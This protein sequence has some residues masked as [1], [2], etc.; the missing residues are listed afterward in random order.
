MIFL[1]LV[2]ALV[3]VDAASRRAPRTAES[4]FVATGTGMVVPIASVV[5]RESEL[6]MQA[7]REGRG[8]KAMPIRINGV[9]D[10]LNIVIQMIRTRLDHVAD[11]QHVR[12]SESIAKHSDKIPQ[13]FLVRALLPRRLPTAI[14]AGARAAHWVSGGT[15]ARLHARGGEGAAGRGHCPRL[16]HGAAG[17]PPERRQRRDAVRVCQTASSDA[18]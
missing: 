15:A 4:F 1:P 12:L 16:R 14:A 9:E 3:A 5:A 7:V 6:V 13:L 11:E 10:D 18:R 2:A 17:R 8:T